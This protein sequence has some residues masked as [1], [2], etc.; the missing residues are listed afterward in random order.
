MPSPD[1][2]SL[3]LS[4]FRLAKDAV[5]ILIWYGLDAHGEMDT[6]F[7]EPDQEYRSQ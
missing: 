2:A 4:Q 3:T 6:L 7:F 5:S 1:N